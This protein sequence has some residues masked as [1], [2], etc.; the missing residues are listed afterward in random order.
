MGSVVSVNLFLSM[1]VNFLLNRT[2]FGRSSF[3]LREGLNVCL[4]VHLSV[5]PSVCKSGLSFVHKF[6]YKVVRLPPATLL[7]F[8][9]FLF[10][11]FC[12][13]PVSCCRSRTVF[14]LS[15]CVLCCWFACLFS[16]FNTPPVYL[17]ANQTSGCNIL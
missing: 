7:L 13:S 6:L 9:P 1:A 4:I 3:S 11:C 8:L 5:C 15:F 17:P 14:F 2:I 16:F 10:R 12:S